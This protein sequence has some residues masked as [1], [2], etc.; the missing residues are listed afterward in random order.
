MNLALARAELA[1]VR[2]LAQPRPVVRRDLGELASKIVIITLFSS[3][4]VRIGADAARTGHVTGILLLASESLVVALTL[5]R[6]APAAVD[7]TW[8]ARLLTAVATFGPPLVRPISTAGS[9]ESLSVLV[10]AAGLLIAVLGKLS[11]GRSFGLA[12]ANR[13]VVR[14][15][16][17]RVVRHPI[18]VGYLVTHVGFVIANPA[19]WNL[20]LLGFADLALMLRACLEERTLAADPAYRDYM[21]V[22][23]WRVLPGVF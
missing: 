14:S 16:L 20:V 19:D 10:S 18:Y 8:T 15:G 21:Q 1:R 23:R 17:Y 9:P 6:R 2:S 4:A 7:R 13:G 3:M 11:L 12:P 5:V 22:V